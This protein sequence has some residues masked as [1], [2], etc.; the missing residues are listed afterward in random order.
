MFS[1][2]YIKISNSVS[3]F[4][5]SVDRPDIE[6]DIENNNI[7]IDK[8]RISNCPVIK[9]K[10]TLWTT[11]AGSFPC[12]GRNGNSVIYYSPNE[13]ELSKSPITLKQ[14]ELDI[15]EYKEEQVLR[16]TNEKKFWIVRK[17]IMGG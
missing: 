14:Y 13:K 6:F 8:L 9:T 4:V 16:T 1:S 12:G 10:E 3:D 11:A 5:Y 15:F 7:K 2:E 17:A